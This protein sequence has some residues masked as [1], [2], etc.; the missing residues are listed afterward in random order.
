MSA[1]M[2]YDQAYMNELNDFGDTQD[3]LMAIYVENLQ[4]SF[5]ASSKVAIRV[6]NFHVL[7]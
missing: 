2:I 7:D 4:S 1:I 6:H 3:S 5:E